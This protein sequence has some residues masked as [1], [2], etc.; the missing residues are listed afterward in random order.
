MK[1]I[2]DFLYNFDCVLGANDFVLSIMIL[3]ARFLALCG[4][5]IPNHVGQGVCVLFIYLSEFFLE[6][7]I[8]LSEF[9]MEIGI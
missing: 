9:N 1:I 5:A 4:N 2:E 7:C 8:Y 3:I 6:Q